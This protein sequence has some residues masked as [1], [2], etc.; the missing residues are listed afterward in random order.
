MLTRILAGAS[1]DLSRQQIHNWSILV[2][3]PYG[4]IK[5]EKTS[6]G[7]LLPAKTTRAVQESWHEPLESH[8]NFPQLTTELVYHFVDH[9]AAHQRLSYCGIRTPLR[10]MR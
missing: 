3:S 5:A 8:R 2:G 4:P 7:A 10:P 6:P 1:R 9:A